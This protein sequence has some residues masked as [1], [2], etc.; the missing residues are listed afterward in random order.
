MGPITPVANDSDTIEFN[1]PASVSEYIDL[2]SCYIRV[3]AKVVK[4][5]GDALTGPPTTNA[6]PPADNVAPT[7]LFLHALFSQIDF[8]VV[9]TSN[10]TYPYKAYIETLLSFGEE[11]KDSQLTAALWYKD[12]DNFQ[13]G[14]DNGG[15]V[16]RKAMAAVSSMIDMAGKL[17]VDMMFQDRYILNQVPMKLRLTRSKDVFCLDSPTVAASFKVQLLDVKFMLRKVQISPVIQE[18]HAKALEVSNAKYPVTRGEC[19]TIL[20]SAGTRSATE[21]NLYNGQLPKR[22]VVGFVTNNALNGAFN[23]NPFHFQHFGLQHIGLTVDG[24]QVPTK[25]LKVDFAS[26]DF[27]NCYLSLFTGMNAFHQDKGNAI[28]REEYKNGYSLVAFNLTPDL[29]EAGGQTNLIKNGVVS[30]EV[31]FKTATTQ[32]INIVVYG[33]FDNLVEIDHFREVLCDYTL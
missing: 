33:E 16:K 26:G 6:D 31:H 10:N 29:E 25:P 8:S 3:K 1:I 28:S 32:A 24:K 18:A 21:E 20:I 11:A 2:S 4:A 19:K 14:G 9:T 5:S 17:H 15:F 12:G 7:N 23:E 22:I 27:I 13:M 30:L